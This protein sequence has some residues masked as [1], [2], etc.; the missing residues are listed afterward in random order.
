MKLPLPSHVPVPCTFQ[1]VCE[2]EKLAFVTTLNAALAFAAPAL[3]LRLKFTLSWE[4]VLIWMLP[5][6]LPVGT[7]RYSLPPVMATVGLTPLRPLL[8]TVTEVGAAP[9]T[10]PLLAT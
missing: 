4:V 7:T 2:V 6:P 9:S 5:L 3:P 1:L 8:F 10:R